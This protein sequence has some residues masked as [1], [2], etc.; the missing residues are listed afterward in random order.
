MRPAGVLAQNRTGRI[1]RKVGVF[2]TLSEPLPTGALP[3]RLYP[4]IAQH[5]AALHERPRSPNHN[6]STDPCSEMF[7]SEPLERN[8]VDKA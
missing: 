8:A 3:H 2:G 4:T 7:S 6:A 1:F 5:N